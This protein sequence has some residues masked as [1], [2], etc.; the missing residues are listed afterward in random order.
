M[1]ARTQTTLGKPGLNKSG[2]SRDP[3]L[4]AQMINGME[5]FPP[6]SRGTGDEPAALRIVKAKEGAPFASMPP[7]LPTLADVP[8]VE[9]LVDKL[10][11]RLQ[12]ERA[13]VRLYEALLSKHDAWGSFPGGPSRAKLAELL[14]EEREHF[15]LLWGALEEL[16]ADPTV[17]TPSAALIATMT[18]GVRAVLQDP[19]T[20]LLQGLQAILLVELDDNEC[21]DALRQLC[22]AAGLGDLAGRCEQAL[23][24]EQEHL[25]LVRRWL[26]AGQGRDPERAVTDDAA[27]DDDAGR[28]G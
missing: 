20:N 18:Q 16:G 24:H 15:Q 28:G 11:E 8:G 2:V 10:G 25:E 14:D 27:L 19:R 3:A 5:E 7:R 26:A 13:G 23:A 9:L 1:I 17:M 12:V 6:S 22:Q 21:W 4:A